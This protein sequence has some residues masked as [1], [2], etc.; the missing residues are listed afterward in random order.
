MKQADKKAYLVQ[1]AHLAGL[2]AAEATA[3]IGAALPTLKPKEVEEL[4]TELNKPSDPPPPPPP[5]GTGTA[6][7]PGPA[8]EERPNV[9]KIYEEWSVEPQYKTHPAERGKTAWK[10]L[11]GFDQVKKIKV[12]AIMPERVA[13]LNE[14]SENTRIRYYEKTEKAGKK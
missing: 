9:N 6:D 10:E 3:Q 7:Q 13:L 11:T 5:P 2:D 8:A 12:V 1:F 14:Q 4:V